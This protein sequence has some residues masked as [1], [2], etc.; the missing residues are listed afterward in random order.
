M[1]RDTYSYIRALR[2]LSNLT[3]SVF[4]DRACTTSLGS[5]F[6]CHT[7]LINL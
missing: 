3:M 2:A 4:R 7:T 1:N 6:Q 5:L